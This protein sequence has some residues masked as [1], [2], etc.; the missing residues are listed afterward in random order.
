[1]KLGVIIPAAGSSA[2]YRDA[3]GMRSKLDEDLGGRPVLQRT[4]ELFTRLEETEAIVVAGPV[5]EHEQFIER[6]GDKLGLL[7]VIV[8]AG[9]RDH[10]WQSVSSALEHLP[11]DL[12]HV[13]IHD[14][15]RPCTPVELIARVLA[16]AEKHD[17]VIPA[18]DVPDTIKRVSP[19]AE[20]DREIDPLDA[21]L[22]GADE[23]ATALRTVEQTVARANLVLVQTPQVF[24]RDLLQRAY[25][26]DDL[27]STDDAALVESLRE[28]VQV[29]E[30]D[31][32]NIKITRPGDLELARKILGVG[33]PKG[34]P[35]HKRF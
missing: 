34:R 15:A 32:R 6:H 7:G 14:A 13:A 26:Q 16:A 4:V 17:A 18:I 31:V 2:R 27:S 5:D 9:G 33:A 3:G 10:R 19:A 8:C 25:A 24:S 28:T 12:T 22:G 20:R 29:V 11:D 23:S 21:I 1:M 30:G 35:V